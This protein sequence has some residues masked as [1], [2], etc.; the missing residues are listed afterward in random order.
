MR[1]IHTLLVLVIA[2][3]CALAVDGA[4]SVQAPPTDAR[5]RASGSPDSPV[6]KAVTTGCSFDAG[7]LLNLLTARSCKSNEECEVFHPRTDF[8]TLGCCSAVSRGVI[9]AGAFD[10]EWRAA[11][12]ACGYVILRCNYSCETA[13]CHEGI[14]RLRALDGGV[15]LLH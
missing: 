12:D 15:D 6:L 3:S 1:P 5:L 11:R 9:Q 14:C 2:G 4:I 13:T 10:R 8:E 7:V